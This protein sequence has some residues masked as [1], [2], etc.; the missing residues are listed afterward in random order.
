[1]K[2]DADTTG[3]ATVL[4]ILA[5]K[6]RRFLQL[7]AGKGSLKQPRYNPPFNQA[8]ED[9]VA[10]RQR[11]VKT[12][13]RT[14]KPWETMQSNQSTLVADVLLTRTVGRL[15]RMDGETLWQTNGKKQ[16]IEE[17]P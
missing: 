8:H 11:T 1:M 4:L 15:A 6:E 16:R 2:T 13:E 9:V 14:A 3:V 17:I 7:T 12:C 5:K 10:N